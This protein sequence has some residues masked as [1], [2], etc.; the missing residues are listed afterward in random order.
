MVCKAERNPEPWVEGRKDDQKV[1]DAF[2]QSEAVLVLRGVTGTDGGLYTCLAQ[3]SVGTDLRSSSVV[4]RCK[5][6]D[7]NFSEQIPK[8]LE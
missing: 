2:G 5:C 3:H 1:G 7:G 6:F 4:V 8:H